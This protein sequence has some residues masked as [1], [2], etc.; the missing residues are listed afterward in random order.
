VSPGLAALGRLTHRGATEAP[1]AVDGCGVLTA[2]PWQ[3]LEGAFAGRLPAARVRVE[4]ELR[5]AGAREV[6]WRMVPTVIS[7]PIVEAEPA[8][9]NQ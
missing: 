3:F 2:I 5:H 4:R 1:G 9:V 7:A 8:A 6:V